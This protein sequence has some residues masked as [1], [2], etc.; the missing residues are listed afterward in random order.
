MSRPIAKVEKHDPRLVELANQ[1][2]Q[3]EMMAT[4]AEFRARAAEANARTVKAEAE[5]AATNA[6]IKTE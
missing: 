6:R 3:E 1:V 5:I 2:K 4:I